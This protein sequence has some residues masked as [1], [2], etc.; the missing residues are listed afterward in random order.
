[1]QSKNI[2]C[3]RCQEQAVSSEP[4]LCKEHFEEY[5]LQTTKETIESFSLFS[6]QSKICV[7]VSGGKDSL[8]LLDVLYRLHYNVE[9]VFVHEG[10]EPYRTTSLHDLRA[11]LKTK[12]IPLQELSF[13]QSYAL[14][15]DAVMHTQQFHA[16]TV[17]G[18]LRRQLLNKHAQ[19]F[20]VLATGHH[21]DDEAQTIMINLAR[22]N[23]ELLFRTGPSTRESTSFKRR[24]KPFYFLL[25][26]DIL[27]Y[28]MLRN[29]R[30]TS[31]TCPY[32]LVSYRHSVRDSFSLLETRYSNVKKHIVN[33]YLTLRKKHLTSSE[34]DIAVC[35]LC[36]QPSQ[37]TICKACQF[38]KQIQEQF[39]E[40]SSQK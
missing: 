34:Y 31:G 22:G 3:A 26:K 12:H 24:V 25:E 10:I 18:T 4:C 9:G 35:K 14:T 27:L 28:S 30:V 11:F 40:T 6:T 37:Q 20:D 7:A 16:C 19:A 13:S 29:I 39:I 38:R 17:C 15:M 36:N 21:L 2:V 8:A 1:M 32:A 33:T 23:T 5:I